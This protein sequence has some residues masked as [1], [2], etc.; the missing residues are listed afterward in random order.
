MP[1]KYI[2][3]LDIKGKKLLIRVDFNVPLDELR[4]ITDD[5]R[6]RA[7]LPTINYA[8]DEDAK[9]ILA[10]HMGM[11]GGKVNKE[12]TMGPVARRLQR[13]LKKDIILAGDCIGNE[14]EEIVEGMD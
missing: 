14:V 11:P 5:S 8:L 3:D 4:N 1:I 6:I 9:V 7:V 12:L 2:D 13:L 10:S